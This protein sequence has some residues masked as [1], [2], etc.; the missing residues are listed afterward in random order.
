MA[1]RFQWKSGLVVKDWRYTV[2]ICNIGTTDNDSAGAI[3]DLG[4]TM[5]VGATTNI[6]HQMT[7][8]V[9]RI[10]NTSMGRPV[11]YMNRTVF[12]GLMRTALEK[13]TS[14]LSISDA[15]TQFG[16]NQSMLSFLGIPI[17]QCDAIIN[18]E[19]VVA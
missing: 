15:V 4:G 12:T 16:T 1:E 2:R 5:A 17:R 10:P 7:K 13:S 18:T 14:A 11:F 3:T 9:A 6:L 19:P 8:A